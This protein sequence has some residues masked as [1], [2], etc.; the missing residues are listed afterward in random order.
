[1][2]SVFISHSGKDSNLVK[3]LITLLRS[4]LNLHAEDIRATSVDGFR[5]PVGY[6]T[7]ELLRQEVNDAKI[8][9]GLISRSSINSAY[10]IFELGARWGSGK[11]MF[12]VLAP[13]FDPGSL[14]GPLRGINALSCNSR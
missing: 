3:R 2:T 1:M 5:L 12:P 7:D 9:I 13:G 4:A 8:L 14:E 6:N 11:P 10:V